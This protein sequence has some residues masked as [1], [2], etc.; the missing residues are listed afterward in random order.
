MKYFLKISTKVIIL[1]LLIILFLSGCANKCKNDCQEYYSEKYPNQYIRNM[2][3][4]NGF[5]EGT[6]RCSG[7]IIDQNN[8]LRDVGTEIYR[9][10]APQ[11]KFA[12]G[13]G[14]CEK[15]DEDDLVC[16]EDC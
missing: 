15:P 7:Y 14:I 2:D 4:R 5:V 12:C 8:I 1:S 10:Q 11:L 13:N 16:P 6:C 9:S 3:G